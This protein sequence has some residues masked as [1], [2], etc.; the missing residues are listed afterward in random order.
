MSLEGLGDGE[1]DIT[2]LVFLPWGMGWVGSHYQRGGTGHKSCLGW[3]PRVAE[4]FSRFAGFEGTIVI[5][6]EWLDGSSWRCGWRLGPGSWVL[7][8]IQAE[9]TTGLCRVVRSRTRA[10]AGSQQPV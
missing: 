1:I 4:V 6:M 5:M 10:L 2:M 8:P 9:G 3:R 7:G